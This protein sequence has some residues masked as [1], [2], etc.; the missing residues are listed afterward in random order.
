MAYTAAYHKTGVQVAAAGYQLQWTEINQLWTKP[1]LK[2]PRIQ[3]DPDFH[4]RH[5]TQNLSI[6][7]CDI[8]EID[9]WC[10]LSVIF[11]ESSF[12]SSFINIF[13]SAVK[14]INKSQRSS[15]YSSVCL[16]Y[17]RHWS[18][19]PTWINSLILTTTSQVGAII[20]SCY[21][22]E[23]WGRERLLWELVHSEAAI[24][25]WVCL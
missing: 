22:K 2:A 25:T 9:F 4:N 16:L 14:R 7:C 13:P 6:N 1:S 5:S 12:L 21:R 20:S 15:Q 10:F 8:W 17:S 24:Q 23:T 19:H 18:T 11:S 3:Q